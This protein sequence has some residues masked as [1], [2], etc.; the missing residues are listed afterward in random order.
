MTAESVGEQIH[1]VLWSGAFSEQGF[2]ENR[3]LMAHYTTVSTL[4][5]IV[6]SSEVWFSNPLYM[7]DWEE[8]RWAM[9]SG[10]ETFRTHSELREACET[11]EKHAVM[12][13]A[14]NA[15]FEDFD[16]NHVL[17]TYLICMSRHEAA[18]CDGVLS[19]WR[20]YGANGSG[21]AIV[22]DAASINV[23]QNS[24]FIVG[25]VEYASQSKRAEWINDKIVG[26][27]R[28][29]AKTDRSDDT[30]K[31]FAYAWLERLKLF[32]LFSKHDGFAEEREWRI[33]YMHDRDKDKL[34]SSMLGYFVTPRG[35]EPKLKLKLNGIPA[36]LGGGL[37]LDN[38]IDRIILG[39]SLST[40]LAG[41]SV[42]RMLE[43]N[44]QSG[45]ASRVTASFIPFRLQ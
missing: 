2:P 9:N 4:E 37:A 26:L 29:L 38:L 3:P 7:N 42:R 30:L 1:S 23:V 35:V 22:F 16:S 20:G 36:A 32:A 40:V 10:A 24:P 41:A 28:I 27:S 11:P 43:L 45:L 8:L 17:D 15:L 12:L 34:L 14:F 21:V 19:M 25:K 13:E 39:P 5:S 44:G 6:K 18:D 33:V 31:K